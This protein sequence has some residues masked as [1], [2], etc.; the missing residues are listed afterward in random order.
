MVIH[1]STFFGKTSS[2]IWVKMAQIILK[3]PLKMSY[4]SWL[5]Y[6][7]KIFIFILLWDEQ[8]CL[9]RRK[10]AQVSIIRQ[11]DLAEAPRGQKCGWRRA[12]LPEVVSSKINSFVISN[13]SSKIIFLSAGLEFYIH[14][15]LLRVIL[16]R[17]WEGV[18]NPFG[19]LNVVIFDKI[20][21]IHLHK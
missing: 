7:L 21:S 10:A 17:M 9:W 16:P 4:K 14:V 6:P 8:A 5:T 20:P 19:F 13:L 11:K 1:K 15:L 2:P 12:F 18:S 3:D